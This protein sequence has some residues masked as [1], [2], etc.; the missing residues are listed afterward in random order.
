MK[1]QIKNQVTGG[2]FQQD[3]SFS[4]DQ[5]PAQE[6]VLS[7]VL[8]SADPLKKAVMS[9]LQKKINPRLLIL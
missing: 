9:G 2:K 1:D 6:S 8:K 7:E 5:M 4:N 3:T